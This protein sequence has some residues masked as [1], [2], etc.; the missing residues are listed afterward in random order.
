VRKKLIA[1]NWKMNLRRESA[2][3]L[4][5]AIVRHPAGPAEVAVFPPFP[6]LGLV[7]DVLRGSHVLWGAQDACQYADGAFTGEV[8]CAM[9]VDWGCRFVILGHSERR[10]VLGESDATVNA[11]VKAALAAGL[12]PIVCVGEPL[13]ERE[14]GQTFAVV[15]RQFELSLAGLTAESMA[16]VVIAYEPI[17]A[18]GTGKVATPEQAQEVHADLRKQVENRYNPS[19]AQQATILYGG[20]VKPDNARS[21]MV[22]PDIDG[23]LVGGAS[24]DAASFMGIVDSSD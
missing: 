18:I 1:G 2:A 17:W 12:R 7:A 24:L 13:A 10:T 3:A 19:L 23:A 6:Y 22:Q 11:K 20:S 15:R 14:A 9:L 16:R 5:R 8:S 21:L 4:A